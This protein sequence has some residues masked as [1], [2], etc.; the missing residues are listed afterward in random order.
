MRSYLIYEKKTIYQL[1]VAICY[2]AKECAD[3]MGIS[4]R[5]VRYILAG[6][7]DCPHFGIFLDD[8]NPA[9]ESKEGQMYR[10]HLP[11]SEHRTE[12]KQIVNEVKV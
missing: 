11:P 1:P 4:L 8:Y 2:T 9:A 6:K 12:I 7:K 5:E 3:F 10:D